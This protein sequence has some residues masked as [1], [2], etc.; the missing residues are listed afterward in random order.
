[1][2]AG[3][4]DERETMTDGLAGGMTFEQYRAWLNARTHDVDYDIERDYQ[5]SAAVDRAAPTV[6]PV[7]P[8]PA[9]PA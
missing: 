2:I 4:L 9:V 1:M 3:A 8:T 5:C 7:A 6:R